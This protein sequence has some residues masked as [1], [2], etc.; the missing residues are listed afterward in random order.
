MASTIFRN[1][2]VERLSTPDRL[3][4][5]LR[6]T[7]PY[8]WVALCVLGGL[9]VISTVLSMVI[10]V[11]VKVPGAGIIITPG[12]VLEVP[13]DGAG[14]LSEILVQ[15]GQHIDKG[16][17]VARLEQPEIKLQL[18][19]AR[20]ERRD[21]VDQR[22]RVAAFQTQSAQ[23]QVQADDQRR[24]DFTQRVTLVREQLKFLHERLDVDTQLFNK[25]LIPKQKLVDTRIAIGKAEEEIADDE[26]RAREIDLDAAAGQ[27][28]AKKEMLDLDLKL[29]AAARRVEALAAR[30]D[31]AET[32]TS[33]YAGTVVELKQN[34]GDLVQQGAA[35]LSLLPDE[36]TD[37]GPAGGQI[38]GLIAM[39]FVPGSEGKKIAPGMTAEV[40][41]STFRRE[42][43]GFMLGRVRSVAA[44]P[45]TEQGMMRTLQNRQLVAALSAGGAP[46]Q[47]EIEID[48]DKTT[49]TGYRWSSSRGPDT[50]LTPGTLAGGQVWVRKIRLIEFVIPALRRFFRD[51]E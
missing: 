27:I 21:L 37:A 33:P 36:Q 26:R 46:F 44:I 51:D 10:S 39:V 16:T 49:P 20:A 12:G 8:G 24:R 40:S 15:S 25:Q 22:D 42:E 43:F 18:D 29:A 30:L 19:H 13:I 35:L 48:R 31:D 3:D 23:M 5:P 11:P 4:Q 34:A 38:S 45:A 14:R 50:K 6:I 9:V 1:S 28:G 41:P 2:A 47:V 17:I 32:V 7:T